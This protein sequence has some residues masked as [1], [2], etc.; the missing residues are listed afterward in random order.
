MQKLCSAFVIG[1][2][3]IALPNDSLARR[4]H[5][6]RAEHSHP[7]ASAS[8]PQDESA[9][10]AITSEDQK[11]LMENLGLSANYLGAAAQSQSSAAGLLAGVIAFI[12]V[13][14]TSL[15]IGAYFFIRKE[16][17]RAI[18]QGV[19]EQVE[20]KLNEAVDLHNLASTRLNARLLGSLHRMARDMCG[21]VN[22]TVKSDVARA[23]YNLTKKAD[24]EAFVE[25]I[26]TILLTPLHVFGIVHEIA[27]SDQNSK[28]VGQLVQTLFSEVKAGTVDP[29]NMRPV[30]LSLI[31]LLEANR[32]HS[33]ALPKLK[34]FLSMLNDVI[35]DRIGDLPAEPGF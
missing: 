27:A 35:D 22:D 4:H 8:S 12:A 6:S 3:L 33:P 5:T 17:T 2:V 9:A 20:H 25:R 14:V 30:V 13:L 16:V 23:G 15:S 29:V 11:R 21:S 31:G 32:S 10:N 34:I 28:H 1:V 24:A 18:S 19:K 7:P 26:S